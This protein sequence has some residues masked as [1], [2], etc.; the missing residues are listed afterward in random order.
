MS[1]AIDN[2]SEHAEG[3]VWLRDDDPSD[4]ELVFAFPL[5]EVLNEAVKRLPKRWFDWRRR[6]WR[7]P[8]DPRIAKLVE[9]LLG[10]FPQLTPTPEVLRWL[11][12]SDRWRG[13]ATVV[14]HEDAGAFLVRTLSG[15]PPSVFQ[16]AEPAGDGKVLLPFAAPGARGMARL[17]G[18]N[19]DDLARTCARELSEGLEPAPAELSVEIGEHGEPDVTLYTLWDARHAQAFRRLPEARLVHRSGRFFGRD[20]AWAVAVP[21]DAAL[22]QQLSEF[23]A[24]RPELHVEEPVRELLEELMA[25]HERASRT[26]AL[27]RAED[28]ELDDL[29]LGGELHPFQRAGVRYA[30]ER[31]RTFIADEQGLGKTV[32]ALATLEADGAFPAVVV[33]P[34]SMKLMWEREASRWLPRRSCAV[35]D[36]R[37]GGTWTEDTLD[38]EIVVLNYDILEAHLAQLVARR[39]RALVLDESHYVKN[40]GARRTKAAIA[41]AEQLAP[42]AL[43]LAL[44]GTPVLNRPD[45]LISQLR[46]L[47]RLGEFGSGARLSRRFRAAASDDRLHWNLRARCYVRRTKAQVLPQLPSKRHDTVPVLLS[48]EHEYRLAEQDVIAWLQT[49]P[50]DLRTLDAKVAAALRA[51]QLVRLNNLRQLAARG[52]L[53]TALAWIGDFLASGEP[54]VVFAEH[55]ATQRAVLERFP[56]AEHILGADSTHNRQRAVDAFQREDGPQL[57][58]CSMKAASQGLTLTRASNVAFLELDWTPARHD[59]AEDRL[60]RIGQESAVTAWYL[61]APNTIDETM[62]E[63]LQRKRSVIDAVTEGQVRDEERLVDAVIRELR[64]KPFRHLRVV[65]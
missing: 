1:D 56:D 33:C 20:G 62:A 23:L 45:E 53:P 14:A 22:A 15:D 49:L 40:P 47:G 27:S 58:V 13:V 12:E 31:R 10:R 38:A 65:A 28:A 6:H 42:E 29:E 26:V 61:L 55:V 48:N 21:A 24:E 35:L 51:E 64:G 39:P 11:K 54:L 8:A 59:Q 57:I 7:V 17:E 18:L 19:L 3:R 32:Q 43:R 25:E 5:D 63:L 41:L 34:A 52:K 50:L 60:H 9:D 30:L 16:G 46:A 44:T 2:D 36:G 4:R 37:N